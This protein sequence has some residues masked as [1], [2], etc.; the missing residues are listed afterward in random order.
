M[1]ICRNINFWKHCVK[2]GKPIH[3]SVAS[4]GTALETEVPKFTKY[5][6]D[7]PSETPSIIFESSHH[8]TSIWN[9]FT[10]HDSDIYVATPGRCGTTLTQEII[11]Q[12]LYNGDYC[13]KL[14][15]SN[16]HELSMWLTVRLPPKEMKLSNFENQLNNP[17]I[18]R[19]CIKLHEPI[20]TIKYNP[21]CKYIFIARDYRDIMWSMYRFYWALGDQLHHIL[22]SSI[23]N[24]REE[25]KIPTIS[26]LTDNGKKEFTEVDFFRMNLT[27]I[28]GIIARNNNNNN[29]KN[30]SNGNDHD[31]EEII[32]RD[33]FPFYSK[34]WVAGS[35]WNA[36]QNFKL[37]NIM[38]IHFTEF[39]KDLRKMIIK[40]ADFLEIDIDINSSEFDKIVQDCSLESMKKSKRSP[41]HT[42]DVVEKPDDFFG[43]APIKYKWQDQLTQDDIQLYKLVAQH[44]LDE[45]GIYWLEHGTF[46]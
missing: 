42:S 25:L 10:P 2:V 8:D 17:N 9:E 11:A 13:N 38:L 24:E 14:N 32:L 46:M 44:Y 33:G 7:G 20:E 28:G 43:N 12:L 39:K 26:E 22:N 16:F 36:T 15:I 3:K 34:L 5:K 37:D 31:K 40:I 27:K 18:K 35:W 21:N 1:K 41:V 29:N 6:Y 23:P 45:Q 4:F 19:R 30:D